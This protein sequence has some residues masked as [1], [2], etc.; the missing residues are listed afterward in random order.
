MR[1]ILNKSDFRFQYASVK[2]TIERLFLF[3]WHP[4]GWRM[5]GQ[6]EQQPGAE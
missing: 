5:Q 1:L 2:G 6:P 3:L 4:E